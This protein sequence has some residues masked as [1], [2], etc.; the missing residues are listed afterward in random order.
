MVN[1]GFAVDD[2]FGRIGLWDLHLGE[3]HLAGM[4]VP[5]EA[6][7]DSLAALHTHFYKNQSAD[8]DYH[9][10]MPQAI[11][12]YLGP[13]GCHMDRISKPESW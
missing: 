7:L 10:T 11:L 8:C 9:T 4:C 5:G 3:A 2:R 13:E 6:R 1:G 12:A